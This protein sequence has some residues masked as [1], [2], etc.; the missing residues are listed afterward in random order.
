MLDIVLIGAGAMAT[1]V[2][3]HLK[4]D[5]ATVRVAAAIVLPAELARAREL[6]PGAQIITAVDELTG[7]PG[8]AVECAGHAGLGQHGVA[9][10]RRGI[11]LLVASTGALSDRA[12]YER[13]VAATKEGGARMLLVSGAVGGI[14]A[15]TAA[16]VAGLTKVVYTSRKP[17]K[18]WKNTPAE[19]V[20]DLD[21][22]AA[23]TVLFSGPADEAARLYPQNA[24]VAATIALA[25]IGFDKTQCTLIADPAANGNIHRIEVQG[26]SG[27]FF[28]EL[29]GKALAANP[30]TS[31]LAALSVVRAIRN[32]SAAIVI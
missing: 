18:S 19:K 27:E 2:V 9:L 16:K 30:K 28:I 32:R 3:T 10:L 14:D 21:K 25:G 5:E 22:V 20:T 13:L 6:L 17:P 4:A 12:L 24:N 11:D 15:L 26:A 29:R 31:M 8:L 7:K 23:A 1:E